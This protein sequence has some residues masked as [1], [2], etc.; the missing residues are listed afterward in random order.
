MMEASIL[1]WVFMLAAIAAVTGTGVIISARSRKGGAAGFS[2]GGR[3]ANAR[4]VAG[5]IAGS[6]IGGGATVGTAQMAFTDGMAAWCFMLGISLGLAALG[7]FYARAL[8][9]SALET[10]P[11]FLGQRY[12]RPAETAVCLISICGI[13]FACASSILP[14]IGMACA[15]L[16]LAPWQAMAAVCLLV[17]GY[18]AIGGQLGAGVSGIIKSALIWCVLLAAAI[19]AW[20]GIPAHS[21]ALPP[22]TWSIFSRGAG[23]A[24]S[25]IG[26][27]VVG[28]ITAQMYIQALFSAT[29]VR[30]AIRGAWLGAIISAPVGLMTTLIGIY[31]RVHSPD[32]PPLLVLPRFLLDELPGWLG[33]LALGAIII[34]IISSAAAQCLAVGTMF[35]RDIAGGV[36]GVKNERG[37]VLANRLG[38]IALACIVG[39]FSLINLDSSVLQ[40][41]YLSVALRGGG[42]F[43]PLSLAVFAP[44]WTQRHLRPGRV[45]ASMLLSTALALLSAKWLDMPPLGIGLGASAAILLLALRPAKRA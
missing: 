3:K 41:N 15:V 16:G 5:A 6:S 17:A 18:V 44:R 13:F 10:V 34:S 2:L 23:Y 39:S 45:T 24:W 1:H 25:C 26:S 21:P 28:I 42:V 7:T 37:L 35:S 4:V 8:R 30:T 43:L 40:W 36:F 11:Q 9:S 19:V 32:T 29:D 20:H 22:H 14:G 12:G 33:G 38:T 27:A 31:M